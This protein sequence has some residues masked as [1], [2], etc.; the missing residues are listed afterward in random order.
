[1]M[2]RQ[3]FTQRTSANQE[4][5]RTSDKS[6]NPYSKLDEKELTDKATA[7]V[8]DLRTLNEAFRKVMNGTSVKG[9][10]VDS[11]LRQV[12]TIQAEYDSKFAAQARD[13][14]EE[15]LRRMPNGARPKDIPSQI[16]SILIQRGQLAGADAPNTIASYIEALVMQ[17]HKNTPPK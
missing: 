7:F 6:T 1:M 16:A 10:D 13:L 5:S 14:E 15:L 17:L 11:M 4:N 2:L 8:K 12:G 3:S 9:R